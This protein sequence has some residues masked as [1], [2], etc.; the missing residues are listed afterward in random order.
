MTDKEPTRY[1]K[2]IRPCYAGNAN[3]IKNLVDE[4]FSEVPEENRCPY[5]RR[6]KIGPY[7]SNGLGDQP[8]TEARRMVCDTSSLQL[9]CLDKERCDICI[10]FR[11]PKEFRHAQPSAELN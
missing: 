8:V 6:D 11:D 7:C 3:A 10:Y 5:L 4:L 9:W 1:I 2:M